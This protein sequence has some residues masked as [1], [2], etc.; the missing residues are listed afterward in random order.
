VVFRERTES[1]VQNGHS[2]DKTGDVERGFKAKDWTLQ[3]M[4]ILLGSAVAAQL[5]FSG[6]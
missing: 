2:T 3:F 4:T 5:F 1:G 6:R